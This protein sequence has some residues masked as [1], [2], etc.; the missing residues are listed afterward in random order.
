[1]STKGIALAAGCGILVSGCARQPDETRQTIDNLVAAGFPRD[2][3][4]VVDGIVYVGRDA[5]V[6]LAASSE[7]IR[8][9]DSHDEQYRTTNLVGPSVTKICVN[10]STFT[11]VFSTA[12]DLAIQN[13]DELGLPFAM[14]R[15]P[16]AG[17]SFTI[18]AVIAPGVVGGSSGFPSGGLPFAT[19]NIGDGLSSFSV[20][21]IEHVITHEIGHTI[22]FRH[23]DFFNRSISCGTGG[24]E[25]DAGVGA[26]LI[27][28]TPSD[29]VVGGSIMNSC[30]RPV[31]TGE[32]TAS[33]LTALAV[34]YPTPFRA[35]ARLTGDVDGDGKTDLIEPFD[36]G[37][38]RLGVRVYHSSGLAY[39]Q[40][41][42]SENLGQ[43][44]GALALLTG[45]VNGDGKTDIIQT[46]DSGGR[47]GI[48]VYQ[49]NGTG[50]VNT[51]GT[52]DA[53][54]GSGALAFLTG[55]V[56]GDGKTDIIQTFNSGGRLG[57]IVYQSNGTGYVSTFGTGDAGQGSGA[58][59][60]LTGDVNGDGKTD[61]I[62]TFDSGGRLGILVYQSNGT[63]Y[64]STFGTGDAG[65]GS[66]A[67]A[68]L[69]GDV[70]G[71][72]RT[73]LLQPWAAPPNLGLITYTSN[74]AGYDVSFATANVGPLD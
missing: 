50:Y 44:S 70:N 52:G 21:T 26:I 13:Y 19:I 36:N 29:A 33:D 73:D 72:G 69:T 3:I 23:S 30:F 59:A 34:L 42:V 53:G 56:N 63:G 7:M 35:R 5:E 22:G 46:F 47:L 28:G 4:M 6:S 39:A 12:L 64:V 25:G 51:F 1:M 74:G 8:P 45:D 65:Q 11:G 18:N 27:P 37:A 16:S 71:D 24:N 38:G 17:C 31:E 62:Q 14:A 43:G 15:T 48:I 68:Y 55:D 41:F 20:D 32:F 9:G 67:L 61:L 66:G 49:S 58:L 60:F 10:G 54:Q 40:S 57:I 2:D